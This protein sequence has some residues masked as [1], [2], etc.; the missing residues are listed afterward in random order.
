MRSRFSKRTAP[1]FVW[2]FQDFLSGSFV[3]SQPLPGHLSRLL[4]THALPRTRFARRVIFRA[5]LFF[6]THYGALPTALSRIH[7]DA[8]APC[9]IALKF[10]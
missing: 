5:P 3:T 7:Y 9:C 4:I 1:A 2:N 10:P 6:Q 8:A